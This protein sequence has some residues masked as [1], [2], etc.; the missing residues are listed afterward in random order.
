MNLEMMNPMTR[1]MIALGLLVTLLV[2]FYLVLLAPYLSLYDDQRQ[3][4]AELT[5][6]LQHYRAITAQRN[7]IYDELKDLEQKIQNSRYYLEKNTSTLASA[8]LQQRIKEIIAR[9]KGRVIS[10]QVA[11]DTAEGTTTRVTVKIRMR[12]STE[13]L[14]KIL[15]ELESQRPLLFFDNVFIR[16]MPIGNARRGLA[17]AN[18]LNIGFDVSAYLRAPA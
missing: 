6:R 13:G 4:I 18:K 9:H 3:T 14:Q 10:T 12:S 15:Y 5:L 11:A 16:S 8:E 2:F 7:S 1:R 17:P